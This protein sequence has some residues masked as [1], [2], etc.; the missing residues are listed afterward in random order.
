MALIK[1]HH[2]SGLISAFGGILLFRGTVEIEWM[3]TMLSKHPFIF[4][5]IGGALLLTGPIIA[6]KLF[7]E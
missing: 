4:I 2:L 7:K 5:V 3:G 6:K 1:Q